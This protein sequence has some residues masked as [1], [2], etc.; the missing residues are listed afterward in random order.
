MDAHLEDLMRQALALAE[1]AGQA[2]EVPIGAV[3]ADESGRIIAA[4]RNRTIARCD[5]TA[6]AEILA[7]RSA[8]QKTGNYRLTGTTLVVTIE[9]CL[10]CMGAL[11][12][13]RVARVVYGAVD[14]KWGGAG[15]L[16]NFA[17]DSR[18]NHS[19]AVEGGVLAADCRRLI[20]DF[21]RQRRAQSGSGGGHTIRG[22]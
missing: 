22:V 18:L 1:K 21:F 14:P 8:T 5:P 9:P 16:Y 15:S 13:A 19:I 4:E 12:H 3:L 17:A 10:M 20:Q 6:H 2:A 11:I 7:L